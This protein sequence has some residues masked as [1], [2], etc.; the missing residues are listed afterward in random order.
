MEVVVVAAMVTVTVMEYLT[1][2]ISVLITHTTDALR[3]EIL[4]IQQIS[5][6]SL[7][8]LLL[9]IGLGTRQ[10]RERRRY[11]DDKK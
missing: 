10:D 1:Q 9:L 3:K 11:C 4:L 5:S 8:L 7:L 2:V 6:R